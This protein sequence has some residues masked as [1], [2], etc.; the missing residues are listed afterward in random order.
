VTNPTP[1]MPSE[2]VDAMQHAL[3]A[4][5]AAVWVYGLVSAF[6]PGSFGS[7][8]DQG[9]QVHT[10]RRDAVT[11]KLASAGSAP[12]S[13]EPAYLTPQ[14]V[15]SQASALAVLVVAET[16]T[17]VAWRSVLENTTDAGVRRGALDGLTDSAVRATRW[18]KAAGQ[19]PSAA[20]LPGQS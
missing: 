5:H 8:V 13:A 14:P 20:A 2:T 3:V 18:R 11:Q 12:K 6:L 9:M 19:T 1:S 7:A 4:E 17:G 16:D 15:T 10:I